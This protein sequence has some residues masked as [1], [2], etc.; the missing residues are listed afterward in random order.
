MLQ[1]GSRFFEELLEAKPASSPFNWSTCRV[2]DLSLADI[3]FNAGC[4]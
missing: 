1:S 3:T 2:V 4:A